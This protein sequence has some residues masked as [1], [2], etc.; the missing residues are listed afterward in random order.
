MFGRSGG[1]GKDILSKNNPDTLDGNYL[2]FSKEEIDVLNYM[3]E[4]KKAGVFKKIVFLINS[5]N[6]V[7]MDKICAYKGDI[8]A[9]LWVGQPGAGGTPA[10][11]KCYREKQTRRV[12]S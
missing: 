3:I 11:P 8:D 1:E 12:G 4:L 6:A 9:C 2:Q 10:L 5:A 7:Q